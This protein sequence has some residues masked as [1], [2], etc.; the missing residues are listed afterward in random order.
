M[1]TPPF[2]IDQYAAAR[3]VNALTAKRAIMLT[4]YAEDG[5]LLEEA[6]AAMHV[7]KA[8]ARTVCRRFLIDF[9]DYRPYALLEKQG[10]PR[11]VPQV[12]ED[13]APHG[14]PLF[15]A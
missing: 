3:G 2:L 14:L 12:R 1:E 11:P 5:R 6:Q 10:K 13:E 15:S 8:T 9:P 7:S 4:G